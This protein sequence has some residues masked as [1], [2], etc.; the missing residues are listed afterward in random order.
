MKRWLLNGLKSALLALLC[1]ALGLAA[2][3]GAYALPADRAV[4]RLD[5]TRALLRAEGEYPSAVRW[6][7]SVLDNYTDC[8]MLHIAVYNA[9]RNPLK[10]ALENRFRMK[11]KAGDNAFA[12]L[13]QYNWKK[14]RKTRF[15]GAYSRYWNGY[16]LWLRPLMM[17]MDYAGIRR[18]NLAFQ[19]LLTAAVL[20]TMARRKRRELILPWLVVW[21]M[22]APP[23]LWQSLQYTSTFAVMS[24][25]ALAVLTTRRQDRLWAV[26]ALSGVAVAFFDFLTYPLAA[27]GV[28]LAI[29]LHLHG[30]DSLKRRLADMAGW[31][32]MWFVGYIGMWGLKWVLASL[33]T[34]KNVIMD[35]LNHILYRSSA[36][37]AAGGRASLA[38]TWMRNLAVVG[39]NPFT[40]AGAAFGIVNLARAAAGKR[41]RRDDALLFGLLALYPFAWYALARNHSFIHCQYTGKA[42]TIT[43]MSLL[44]L[45]CGREKGGGPA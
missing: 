14:H 38:V 21:G 23:A 42:L 33:L 41:L 11:G 4:A 9:R 37:D 16:V 35:A 27:L 36:T 44:C 32:A 31:S 26:F 12:G 6:C 1:A 10:L 30:E 39:M 43:A 7:Y 8:W 3:T 13:L 29:A 25:T 15:E 28:P 20:L 2:L 5:D 24:L 22:L 19:L 17:V 18:V 45:S 34:D 40:V